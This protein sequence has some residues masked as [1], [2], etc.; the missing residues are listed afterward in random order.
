MNEIAWQIP[1]CF[2][3]PILFPPRTYSTS[4]ML[5]KALVEER[6]VPEAVVAVTRS[7]L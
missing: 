2:S 1:S 4:S 5:V 6:A 7:G 3:I